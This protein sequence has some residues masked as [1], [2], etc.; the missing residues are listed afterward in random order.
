M[1]TALTFL[2]VIFSAFAQN[3]TPSTS[4]IPSCGPSEQD[5][6]VKLDKASHAVNQPQPGRALIYVIEVFQ[7]PRKFLAGSPTIRI[8]LDG[9]WMGANRGNSYLSFSVAPG[10]HHLCSYW[11]SS[12]PDSS[13]QHSFAGFSAETGKTY[14]FR[15]QTHG[16]FDSAEPEIWSIDL[17]PID[18]DEGKYLV[19]SY[20]LS[21]SHPKKQN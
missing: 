6:D 12:Q 9:F 15:V 19:A 21:I 13:A 4:P 3:H 16:E 10:E 18:A 7:V 2:F 11:Q 5:F 17:Q 20:P 8:G 1:R 14:F